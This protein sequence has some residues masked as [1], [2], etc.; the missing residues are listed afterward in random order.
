MDPEAFRAAG[1]EVVDVIA[2]YLASIEERPVF[3]PVEPGS[4]RPLFAPAAPEK[5]EPIAAILADYQR[6]VEPN[7][8]LAWLRQQ[9]KGGPETDGAAAIAAELGLCAVSARRRQ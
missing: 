5:P 9:R 8:Y 2:D 6:L 7:A 3:P 1:H 4:L